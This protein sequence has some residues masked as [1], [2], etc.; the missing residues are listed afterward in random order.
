MYLLFNNLALNLCLWIIVLFYRE[1][2]YKPVVLACGHI[3]CFWCVFEAM[4]FWQESHCP[5]CRHAYYH[6]PSICWLLHSV[7]LKLYPKAYQIRESQVA[8]AEKAHGTSS[9]QFENYLAVSHGSEQMASQ[10]HTTAQGKD[11]SG[12]EPLEPVRSENN[13]TTAT[14][15]ILTN[16]SD[17][18]TTAGSDHVDIC[19]K[20]ISIDDLLCSVCKEL[21]CQPVVLNC[22]HGKPQKPQSHGSIWVSLNSNGSNWPD[23]KTLFQDETD[24]VG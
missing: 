5:V 19:N 18:I 21:L 4:D 7:L 9:P 20:Q 16:S 22:G 8:K 17:Q 11:C 10:C 2:I 1:L 14:T 6:F 24:K 15:G 3:S 12:G 13:I 23:V